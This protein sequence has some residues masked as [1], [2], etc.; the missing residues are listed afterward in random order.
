MTLSLFYSNELKIFMLRLV[1]F[2]VDE[3]LEVL[4]ESFHR[5]ISG[6]QC[7]NMIRNRLPRNVERRMLTLVR[8]ANDST[9]DIALYN[10]VSAN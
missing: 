8:S 4:D 5:S 9:S 2:I 3:N 7:I 1:L 10:K 6:S